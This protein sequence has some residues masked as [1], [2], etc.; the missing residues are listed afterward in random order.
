MEVA[1]TRVL[2]LKCMVVENEHNKHMFRMCNPDATPVAGA[3]MNFHKCMS[4]GGFK[5]LVSASPHV[6]QQGEGRFHLTQ[7]QMR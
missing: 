7:R 2:C 3:K 1:M 6:M 5:G 4:S